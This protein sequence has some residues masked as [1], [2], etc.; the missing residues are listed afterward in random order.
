VVLYRM[1][2]KVE[3]I[4][5][6]ERRRSYLASML[7]ELKLRILGRY[8]DRE[9]DVY[10]SFEWAQELGWS[11]VSNASNARLSDGLHVRGTAS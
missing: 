7:R 4:Y 3:E 2:C 11:R 10:K 8:M 5:V 6:R 1:D 9:M